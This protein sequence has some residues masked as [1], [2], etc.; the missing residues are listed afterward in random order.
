MRSTFFV[1]L[2]LAATASYGAELPAWQTDWDAAF[3]TAKEQH[4]LVFVNY[5]A[6][7]CGKCHDVERLTFKSPYIQQHL[8]DF[9]LLEVD[10]DFSK[11]AHHLTEVPA[12]VVYD[13]EGRERFQIVGPDAG[14]HLTAA[15]LDEIRR[16]APALL[17][18]SDLLDAKQDLEAAFLLANTYSRLKM[19]S[20]ARTEYANARQIADQRG[21][22]AAAQLADAQ[23]A[24]TFALEGNAPKAIKQLKALAEKP[25][26]RDDEAMIWLTLG[27]AYEVAKDTSS[28]RDAYARA[29]SL[30]PRDSRTYTEARESIER[31]HGS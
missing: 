3:K 6:G 11:H 28:A 8:A 27:H 17:K 29:Q 5:T 4:R 2:I 30:A 26:N 15:S 25:V 31:L 12:Y 16:A 18:T 7:W 21:D 24:F 14:S 13:P 20:R 23:S 19:A 9:V 22:P 1:G 10:V